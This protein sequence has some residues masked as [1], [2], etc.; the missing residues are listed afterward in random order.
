MERNQCLMLFD[1]FGIRKYLTPAERRTFMEA[2]TEL[3]PEEETFCVTLADTGARI[4]EVLAL[5]PMRIDVSA[6]AVVIESLK[7][8][9]RG[10]FR[11][12]PVRST[13]IERLEEV[14]SISVAAADPERRNERIWK[15]GRTKAWE[16]VRDVMQY[17]QVRGPWATP[18]GLRHGFG[19]HG[20]AEAGVPLNMMQR[21]LGHARLETTAIYA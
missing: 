18:K 9:R 16:R 5:T 3:P 19:V 1:Q 15:W 4:S 6:L 21:W 11:A 10:V 12:V 20:V 8:R 13:L 17:A 2:A 14:H 7:K